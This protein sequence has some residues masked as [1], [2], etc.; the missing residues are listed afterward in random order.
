[1]D[2]DPDKDSLN[3]LAEFALNSGP[4][5]AADSGKV[6]SFVI[7]LAGVAYPCLTLP[8][9]DGIQFSGTPAATGSGSGIL[10]QIQ[11]AHDLQR[12]EVPVM[13]LDSAVTTGLP[14]LDPGWSY[15]S[16]RTSTPVSQEQRTFLRAKLIT[17]P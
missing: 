11:G 2:A 7:T 13:E 8:V 16:F 15:R 12:W 17:V 4:N 3:N 6:Q 10:Y 9:R 14:V 1:M 5:S